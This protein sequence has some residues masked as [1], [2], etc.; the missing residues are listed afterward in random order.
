MR[1]L[2]CHVLITTQRNHYSQMQGIPHTTITDF[3][4]YYF[5][6][7]FNRS[8]ILNFLKRS[9]TISLNVLSLT[10]AI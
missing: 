5:W 2:L 10:L 1:F 8:K 7:L 6:Q 4:T 3:I 9:A